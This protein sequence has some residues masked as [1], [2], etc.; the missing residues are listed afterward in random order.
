M[1]ARLLAVAGF[2]LCA[3]SQSLAAQC[4]QSTGDPNTASGARQNATADVCGQGQDVFNLMAPQLGVLLTGG[5]ATLGQGGTLGGIGHFSIGVRANAVNGDVPEIGQFP[6]P[7]TSANQQP[8]TLR[9]SR[10]A[11]PLPAVDAA[12][13]IFRGIPLGLTNVGGVDL[14]VSATYLPTYEDENLTVTPESNLKIGFGARVGLLQESLLVPG[15]SVTYLKRD[16]PTTSIVATD[17][18]FTFAINDASVETSAWRIV[19]NKNLFLFGLALGYGQDRYDQSMTIS[20]EARNIQVPT[21]V[22]GVTLRE[23]ATLDATPFSQSLTRSNMFA[24][25]SINLFLAKL[26]AEVGRVT[27]GDR[28]TLNNQFAGDDDRP[29]DVTKART[30]GSVGLRIGF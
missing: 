15:V 16:L 27:G 21:G 19:A 8:Q 5:N 10:Q 2:A 18:D 4:P 26:V 13:G 12:I 22:G 29:Y 6:A 28:V 25:V 14:L 30:Y 9:T 11:L 3:A 17:Q 7:R 20:G 1:N 23:N 24:D